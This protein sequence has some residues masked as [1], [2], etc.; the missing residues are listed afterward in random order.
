MDFRWWISVL[1]SS[2]F[3][4]SLLDCK[5]DGGD[6]NDGSGETRNGDRTACEKDERILGKEAHKICKCGKKPKQ[7]LIEIASGR[8][9]HVL[10]CLSAWLIGNVCVCSKVNAHRTM[11]YGL[12]SH[13]IGLK[14]WSSRTMVDACRHPS[15]GEDRRPSSAVA[16]ANQNA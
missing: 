14:D 16:D 1:I 2:L 11:V 7:A 8:R 9:K 4:F 12:D 10:C 6:E 15:D 3:A 13:L 5:G